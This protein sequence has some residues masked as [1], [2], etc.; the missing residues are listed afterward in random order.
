VVAQT[1]P[2]CFAAQR[3]LDDAASSQP[4]QALPSQ[5]GAVGLVQSTS[6]RHSE[7]VDATQKRCVPVPAHGA[8][9]PQ[10]QARLVHVSASNGLHA[11][12]LQAPHW[13]GLVARQAATP[14]LSQQS[15][16]GV[17]PRASPGSH[18]PHCPFWVPVRTHT[19][20]PPAFTAQR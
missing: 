3:A 14:A 2:A 9:V 5:S 6:V 15:W 4:T 19:G 20:W 18:A 1:L 8:V 16:L 12:A 7:Q 11:E 17:H 10:R 13:V